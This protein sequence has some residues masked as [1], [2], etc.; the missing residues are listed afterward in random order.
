M[1]EEPLGVRVWVFLEHLPFYFFASGSLFSIGRLIGRPIKIDA[2]TLALSRPSVEGYVLRLI[3]IRLC[4]VVF[5]SVILLG[6]FGSQSH[7]IIYLS[8]VLSAKPSAIFK[9]I[10]GRK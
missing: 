2:A 7:M 10:V 9:K 1:T 5:G 3:S 6:V 8:I 4:Q